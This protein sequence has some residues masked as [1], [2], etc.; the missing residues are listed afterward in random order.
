[1]V[2]M[3][4]PKVAGASLDS[5]LEIASKH[6]PPADLE[7]IKKAY[8]MAEVAHRGQLRMSGDPYIQHPLATAVTIASLRMD[9]ALIAAGLLHD[10]PEDTGR[11]L[12][13][14]EEQFGP[15]VAKLVDGVT[16]LSRV[17][18]VPK[19]Q[20]GEGTVK[21]K[22]RVDDQAYRAENVRKMFL[23][24]A[25]DV[26]VVLVKLADRLHNMKTL[27]FLPPE[28][29]RRIA[30]E[31]LE[32]Y[33]PLA[34]RLGIWQ[35]KWQL[36]DLAFRHLEP[37]KYK[38]IAGSIKSRRAAR[39]RYISRVE[40]VLE[41][42]L[43]KAAIP[44]DISGRPKHI[45]SI[46]RKMERQG[47]DIS[48]IYDLQAVRI[49]VGEV[50]DCYTVLGIVHSLWHPLPGQ[51]DDYIASPK[52]SMYQSLHTTV[53]CLDAKPL[54][55]QIRTREMHQLAEYGVASHWRYKE[56]V[57]KDAKFDAKIAWLRQLM[58]W[59]QD[60]M[61]GAQEF[62]DSLRT[63]VFQD[64]VYV[65][66]P[67]GEIK[68]LTAGATPLD[69]AYR[70][71]TDV[72][73]RCVGGKV[74]GRLVSLDY[75]LKNGDIVEILTSKSSR[76][77]SRDWLNPNLNYIKTIHARD[78]IRQ[79]FK[80]Q[81]RDENIA[82]GREMLEKELKRLGLDFGKLDEVASAF[83]YEKSDDFL[84]A[85]GYGDINTHQVAQRLS[86]A[87]VEEELPPTVAAIPIADTRG[88]QVQGVGDL[89]TRLARCCNPVPGDP[90]VGFIT[91]G[92]GVTVH[93]TDCPSVINEDE[94][95]R[96]VKVEWGRMDHQ[97]FP[98]TI[99]VDA[100]DR[101]G[102]VRDVAAVVADEKVNIASASVTVHKDR[103][104]TLTATLEIASI[105]RLAR[106]LAKVE[107]IKDVFSVTRD[108]GQAKAV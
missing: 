21:E 86:P 65:F 29:R 14:I 22:R 57:K 50:R 38:E 11:P 74:N 9:A 45:Y 58:D 105:D 85:V 20:S 97:T 18:W 7:V 78:K 37:V 67:K 102:L 87:P 40:A 68:E 93:R 72:G 42:E 104:A 100:W 30:Q 32:I 33:A 106:V 52:E 39:E 12:A 84:A 91:R 54:E 15:E 89:L 19:E 28:K 43:K 90:I 75:Q 70:V 96:L 77:P 81:Q 1:L 66:T 49:I 73:H 62:V 103:T 24:M 59:Q 108:G 71:H 48:Q 83:K 69:F 82:R 44:A 101:E 63:D 23:A 4:E 47:T 80:K 76:G 98:V 6:L 60:M 64:Q 53:L 107:G 99:R 5:L 61:I 8:E 17:R 56:G 79:W 25:D 46:Y 13:L 31:T 35:I 3:M 34:N 94:P 36:E 2:F 16:K 95:E 55:I 51:F 27:G 88:I 41:E 92:K 10:V 26:R